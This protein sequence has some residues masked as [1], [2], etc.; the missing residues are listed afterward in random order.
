MAEYVKPAQDAKKLRAVRDIV[1]IIFIVLLLF[2]RLYNFDLP[3]DEDDMENLNGYHIWLSASTIK[4]TNYWLSEGPQNLHWLM[5]E[6][7]DSI[8]ETSFQS[9][10]PYVSYPEGTVLI[11]YAYA[12]LMHK[13]AITIRDVRILNSL[14]YKADAVLIALILYILLKYIIKLK[15]TAANI[16]VPVFASLFWALLPDNVYY[17]GNIFFSDMAV[18]PFAYFFI[19]TDLA[20]HFTPAGQ[21][22]LWRLIL[23]IIEAATIFAA[24]YIDY[25]F[26]LIVFTAGT[27]NFIIELARRKGLKKAL[28]RLLYYGLPALASAA[29]YIKHISA[30]DNWQQ[31]LFSKAAQRMNLTSEAIGYSDIALHLQRAYYTLGPALPFIIAASVIAAA[32]ILLINKRRHT[33][34]D[35]LAPLF[36]AAAIINLPPLMHMLLLTNHWEHEFSI[37]KLGLPVV[38]SL[39]LICFLIFHIAG[40]DVNCGWEINF[41][42][43]KKEKTR[44]ISAL[45]LSMAA[46]CMAGYFAFNIKNTT[47]YYYTSRYATDEQYYLEKLI[48]ANTDYYDV[49]FSDSEEI[50]YNPPQY[51]VVSGKL[52]Y[53]IAA[54]DEIDTMFPELSEEANFCFIVSND[55]SG[56][57]EAESLMDMSIWQNCEFVAIDETNTYTLYRTKIKFW[58]GAQ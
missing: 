49:I 22:K 51:P 50:D 32:V 39:L 47:D 12:K 1:L 52:V 14:F 27:A 3:Y 20:L 15:N 19:L 37:L 38:F 4:F 46:I 45:A 41:I 40:A 10:S 44:R 43:D 48:A 56:K 18:L 2:T 7:P 33:E 54:F 25:Y 55:Y 36:Y 8:E 31:L 9:R 16:A 34:N 57:G 13:S 42:N 24:C 26:W 23:G 30:V 11:S 35:T 17:L 58:K 5:I 21:S 53:K 29:L 28:L 6:E